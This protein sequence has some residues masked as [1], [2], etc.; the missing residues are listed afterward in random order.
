MV[1]LTLI[2]H[3]ET[4]QNAQNICQG[5]SEGMLNELGFKQAELVGNWLQ[6]EEVDAFFCSDMKRTRDTA[7]GI[8]KHHAQWQTIETPVLRERAMGAME[9]QKFPTDFDWHNMPAD[10]ETNEQL[11]DRAQQF[12][13]MLLDKY[14]GQKVMAVSHG[15]LIRAFWTVLANRPV[16]TYLEWDKV[17]NTAITR[18]EL[19]LNGEHNIVLRNCVDHL[20]EVAAKIDELF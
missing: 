4:V 11:C 3:G 1:E 12:I 18:C 19:N 2:R 8:L 14:D 16:S 20:K 7:T 15:G 17:A 13:D 10:M 9:G 6:N 5:Q